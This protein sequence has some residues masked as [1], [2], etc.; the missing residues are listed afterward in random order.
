MKVYAEEAQPTPFVVMYP[1]QD[2]TENYGV[3]NF[4]KKALRKIK[5]EIS[6]YLSPYQRARMFQ[7]WR[8]TLGVR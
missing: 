1:Y 8:N 3:D 4:K 5:P 7:R 2:I 6:D